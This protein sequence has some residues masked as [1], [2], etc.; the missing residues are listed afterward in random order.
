VL[1]AVLDTV[2]KTLGI[3]AVVGA[4]EAVTAGA[5]GDGLVS[6]AGRPS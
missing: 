4:G 1:S 5:G 3:A 6:A 2:S